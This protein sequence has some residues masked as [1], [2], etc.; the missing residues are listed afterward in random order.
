VTP[1][2][3]SR[4][5]DVRE[6]MD[7]PDCDP[8]AL[9]RTYARFRLVNRLVSG[10]RRTYLAQI[11]PLLS[12]SRS[13]SLLDVGSGG[14]DVARALAAW[15]RADGLSLRV[16]GVDPDPRAHAFATASPAPPGVSFRQAGCAEL[17]AAGERYDVVISNHLLHHLD[18]PGLSRLLQDS[19]R[20]A[21]RRVLHSD[22]RRSRLAYLGWAAV[23]WPAA[24]DTFV[25]T[26]GL[27]SIRRSYRP[28]E[29]AAAVPTGWQVAAQ[30]PYRLLL[31]W[32]ASEPARG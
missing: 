26:D 1:D 2:L 28:A 4:D 3:R 12:D 18:A 16:V 21:S 22:L 23:S 27:L 32:N 6:L 31:S 10:W 20:L 13:T 7:D 15:A 24:R 14:G 17:V 9:D 19:Q 30:R 5:T 29:L 11:R 8:V 25:F